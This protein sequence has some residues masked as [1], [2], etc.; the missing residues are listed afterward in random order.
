MV[1][2]DSAKDTVIF[3]SEEAE[4]LRSFFFSFRSLFCSAVRGSCCVFGRLRAVGIYPH[5]PFPLS[6]SSCP[7][8]QRGGSSLVWAIACGQCEVFRT[9]QIPTPSFF[10][11]SFSFCPSDPSLTLPY[12]RA[13][14][15]GFYPS[16]AGFVHVFR[17]LSLF[18]RRSVFHGGS[19]RFYHLALAL[20]PWALGSRQKGSSPPGPCVSSLSRWLV[21]LLG[22]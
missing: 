17:S 12:W 6:S 14:R 22:R 19:L 20:F 18:P 8:S 16:G 9:G 3:D 10:F 21:M 15:S 11:V 4:R 2:E 1:S 13:S 7:E 5:G